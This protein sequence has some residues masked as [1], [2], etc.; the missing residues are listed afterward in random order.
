[1]L[2]KAGL[3]QFFSVPD[4][5]RTDF[6]VANCSPLAFIRPQGMNERYIRSWTPHMSCNFEMLIFG[7]PLHDPM[8][9][10]LTAD[11]GDVANNS[12]T[13]GRREL[14]FLQIRVIRVIHG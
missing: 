12:R 1:L 3:A 9:E 6:L 5:W 4:A 13:L 8:P 14:H 7:V 11:C 2:R 10:R